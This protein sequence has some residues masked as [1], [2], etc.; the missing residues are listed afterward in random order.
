MDENLQNVSLKYF[1]IG[2]VIPFLKKYRS[3]IA[4]MLICGLATGL[5]DTILPLFGRYALNHYVAERTL[6]TLPS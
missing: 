6:D 3:Q 1:G 2:K 4:V 5:V